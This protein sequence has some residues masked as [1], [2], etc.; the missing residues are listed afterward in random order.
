MSLPDPDE[1]LLITRSQ[2]GDR[3]AMDVL[4][5][6]YESY[7]YQFAVR[8]C[9][10]T[11]LAEDLTSE[12][13]IRAFTH[14]QTFRRQAQFKTWLTR[15]LIN[16]FYDH[17]KQAKRY[18]TESLEG[19]AEPSREGVSKEYVSP[20]PTPDTL[21]EGQQRSQLLLSAILQLPHDQRVIIIMY[22]IQNLKYEEIAEALGV[23]V[24]TVKSRLNRAR[25][26]LRE[27][28]APHRE[29]FLP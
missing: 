17:S 22:H 9:G 7:I 26:N 10:D 2:K 15:I 23:P 14:I 29:L 21:L 16:A 24:G 5:R 25:L 3:D 6:K 4:V 11:S 20:N 19:L 1:Q 13:F 27:I 18:P 8:L 28:L 12:T